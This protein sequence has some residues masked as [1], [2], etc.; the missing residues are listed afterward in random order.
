[1]GGGLYSACINHELLIVLSGCELEAIRIR[2]ATVSRFSGGLYY[3]WE[4]T[5][6][7]VASYDSFL[8]DWNCL[9]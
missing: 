4:S 1:V 5:M 9:P 3:D 8:F 7:L 6:V 2:L